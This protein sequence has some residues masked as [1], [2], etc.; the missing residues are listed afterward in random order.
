[1][2]ILIGFLKAKCS[3]GC[4]RCNKESDECLICDLTNF[5]IL[6]NHGLCQKINIENCLYIETDGKCGK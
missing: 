3:Q 6:D 1:M 5:F 2:F 4:L